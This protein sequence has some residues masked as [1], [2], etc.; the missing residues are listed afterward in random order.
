MLSDVIGPPPTTA[1]DA[2]PS[3]RTTSTLPSSSPSESNAFVAGVESA[4]TSTEMETGQ[5]APSRADESSI[6]ELGSKAT[7]VDPFRDQGE[8]FFPKADVAVFLPVSNEEAPIDGDAISYFGEDTNTYIIGSEPEEDDKDTDDRGEEDPTVML[9]S[10]HS[11]LSSFTGASLL[12]SPRHSVFGEPSVASPT[13]SGAADLL[14]PV[15]LSAKLR[16]FSIPSMGFKVKRGDSID[17]GYA[18]GESWTSPVPFPHSP[19][20]TFRSPVMFPSHSRRA[21]A[22][23][24]SLKDIRVSYNAGALRPSPY[25]RIEVIKEVEFDGCLEDNE[26]TALAIL[27]AYG[28]SPSEGLGEGGACHPLQVNVAED[29]A[30]EDDK[31]L[32]V[33][34]PRRHPPD[35]LHPITC[36][37]LD[38]SSQPSFISNDNLS[39]KTALSLQHSYDSLSD[40]SRQS[41]VKQDSLLAYLSGCSTPNTSV[42]SHYGD[43][44]EF[45]E[46]SVTSTHVCEP[47]DPV[48]QI[49]STGAPE[50]TASE[51]RPLLGETVIGSDLP[52]GSASA[53]DLQGL[54]PEKVVTPRESLSGAVHSDRRYLIPSSSVDS[55]HGLSPAK[56]LL[57]YALPD[58]NGNDPESSRPPST[59]LHDSLPE[60]VAVE[61]DQSLAVENSLG[62]DEVT[63][64]LDSEGGSFTRRLS[65][66]LPPPFLPAEVV[67]NST[68]NGEDTSVRPEAAVG[69]FAKDMPNAHAGSLD[70][71]VEQIHSGSDLTEKARPSQLPSV[72]YPNTSTDFTLRR[73]RAVSDITV[74]GKSPPATPPADTPYI[75]RSPPPPLEQ[76]GR[77]DSVRS[78]YDQYFDESA[79]DGLSEFS[80]PSHEDTAPPDTS[81]LT[82]EP[83]Q[84]GHL[85]S[86]DLTPLVFQRISSSSPDS[87][88]GDSGTGPPR[89][90]AVFRPLLTGRRSFLR[91]SLAELIPKANP[92][93][94]SS[95]TNRSTR[96]QARQI[97]STMVPLGFRR[98]KPQVCEQP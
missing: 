80:S 29:R 6:L 1:E 89:S 33:P 7:L 53:D 23:S 28:T 39:F 60:H 65:F 72:E 35:H 92:K 43:A 37:D 46:Q 3:S 14:S 86:L 75:L 91:S 62:S 52:L 77:S 2:V 31:P 73:S 70:A 84:E 93:K 69:D 71:D 98:H 90:E 34:G 48:S 30:E 21:S 24:P 15:Q 50:S 66:P 42:L 41:P 83:S 36:H 82:A 12:A 38:L 63:E 67:G 19:P 45:L 79:S 4:S 9:S 96:V 13:G 57:G 49:D 68:L 97:G 5:S 59:V 78:L 47:S 20:G 16:P 51:E 95:H 25:N 10:R 56:D 61:A 87:E 76:P 88:V 22:S 44:N 54:D 55:S 85:Q 11:T 40:I 94:S 81:S 64:C 8:S 17:S 18:D 27:G 74:K 32:D 58:A 26:D